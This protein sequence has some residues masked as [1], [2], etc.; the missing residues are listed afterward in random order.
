MR[1]QRF[2]RQ[3]DEFIVPALESP[4]SAPA[5]EVAPKLASL[6]EEISAIAERPAHVTGSGSTIFV[7][8]DAAIHSEMLANALRERLEH[9]AIAVRV[10]RH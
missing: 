10:A 9:P 2:G 6:L 3:V 8:C 5:L 7:L 4:E 1:T